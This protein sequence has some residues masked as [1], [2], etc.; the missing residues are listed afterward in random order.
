MTL[1]EWLQANDL[2][3]FE[4]VFIENQIDLKTMKILTEADLK[5]LGFAFGPRKRILNAI[6]NLKN[7]GAAPASPAESAGPFA[8][9][10]ERRQ[11]TVMF[12]DLVGSTALSNALDPEELHSLI[13]DYRNTCCEVVSRYEGYVAQY[14]GDGLMIYFGWPIAYEDAAERSVRS[15]LEIVQAVKAIRSPTP[16]QVRIG[17]ATGSVVVGEMA[18]DAN[19]EAKLAV[20]ETPNLAARVQAKAAPG[21]VVIAQTTRRLLGDTFNLTDLGLH[22]LKG[23]AQ[24]MQLWRVD[25]VHRT[26]GRFQAA[27]GGGKVAPLFGRDEELSLLGRRW[28]QARRGDGQVVLIGGQAGIG[29]SRLTQGLRDDLDEPYEALHYQCS[30]YHLNSPL[31]PFI[32]QFELSAGFARDDEP[33]ERLRKME[34]ALAGTVDAMENAAP[35]FATLL[36]L[37]TEG[38]PPLKLSP[39]KRKEK[40]M[41]ALAGRVEALSARV[42]V[43][44][45]VEDIHWIDPTSQELLELLVSKVHA[46]PVLLVMTHRPELEPMWAGQASVTSVTLHRLER[47]AGAELVGSVTEGRTLPAEVLDEILA[48]ADGVPLFV[49][50]LT[51][52]LLETGQL[53]S[54]GDQ[55]VLKSPL[56]N[57]AIPSSLRDLLS[58]RLDRLGYAKEFAQIGACIGREFSYELVER[59]SSLRAEVLT[60]SLETLVGS[61]LVTRRDSPPAATYT[62]KHALVQDAAYE[63]MLK[64]RRGE[65]HARIAN[66]LESDFADQV[67]HAPE[68]VAHHHTLAGHLMEAIPLWRKAGTMA[69]GRVAL[70]EAVAH[71][72][73][74]LALVEQLP[75]SRHRDALELTIREPLNAAWTGLRGWAAPEVGVNAAAILRL[76]EGQSN[77]RS[78]MLA[79]WWVWTSTITQGRIA[80][81]HQWVD[82]LLAAGRASDNIDMRMFGHVTAMVQMFLNGRLVESRG[83]AEQALAIYD[84]RSAERWIQLTG[85]NL[86][87][88]VEV[89]TCQLLWIM[90]YLEQG[91]RLSEESVAHGRADGH[92]FNL[93][94]ALTF[95]AYVFAYRR[96]PER[97]LERVGEAERLAR[98]Q[99]LA[100]IYEVSVPQARGIAELQSG[101]PR[102]AIALLRRGIERWTRTGGNVRIPLVKSALAEAVA[103]DGDPAEALELI[104]ECLEQINRPEGQ[105]RLWLAE[106]LRRK[107]WIL[108]R[109]GRNADAEAQLRAAIECAR[110]QQAKAWELRSALTL[111]QFLVETARPEAAREVLAP[112]YAWFTEGAGTKDLVEAKALLESVKSSESA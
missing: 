84:P 32:E 13:T 39:Q 90:G 35:L 4:A 50:E 66:V 80:D 37:P 91:N 51:R 28:L 95:S 112:I 54:D 62:F 7:P 25:E 12:C 41:E 2:A 64:S 21:E 42:P 104:D 47:H 103:L 11:L 98:D 110:E 33:T 83:H 48:R 100:F 79:M 46:L 56:A 111:A 23:I 106:V 58:A 15:S 75:P 107:G 74:G 8:A 18:G 57:L 101:R 73:K 60:T 1:V 102:E 109:L 43:L 78:L 61:G 17:L 94:W 71:F 14:L 34:A 59:I 92:A 82:R 85:H 27:R 3:E 81:S 77:D 69:V 72:Q 29:K 76:A 40:T 49:E 36:S 88:F 38:Y 68:W 26:E 5:E 89:Y 9:V 6:A 67:A 45:V 105:E 16:L 31:H 52:S 53:V 55:Y 93:V 97:F 20:G 22:E 99:G 96:E 24:P 86:R 10:G 70:K 19:A 30:P 65:L 87:T 108:T 44:M 63:S